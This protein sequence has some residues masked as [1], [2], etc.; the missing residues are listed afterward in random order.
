MCRCVLICYMERLDGQSPIWCVY[1]FV[2]PTLTC[3]HLKTVERG[4]PPDREGQQGRGHRHGRA[5]QGMLCCVRM[6]VHRWSVC[7][8]V[9]VCACVCVSLCV[10]RL[11]SP[12]TGVSLCFHPSLHSTRPYNKHNNINQPTGHQGGGQGAGEE[13]GR[14]GGRGRP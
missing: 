11:G 3:T 8:C 7:V 12:Y 13:E 9:C 14:R 10:F 4:A 6:F 2:G 5:D 1:T